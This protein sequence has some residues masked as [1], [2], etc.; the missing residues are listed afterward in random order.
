MPIGAGQLFHVVGSGFDLAGIADRFAFGA[1]GIEMMSALHTVRLVATVVFALEAL[2][3]GHVNLSVRGKHTE[4]ESLF[5]SIHQDCH[6][7]F[8]NGL[9]Q[10]RTIA[11]LMNVQSAVRI[12][13]QLK[14]LVSD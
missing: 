11:E 8:G 13:V 7:L 12:I 6:N 2:F 3:D 10:A 9:A 14:R 1:S 4:F 5:V